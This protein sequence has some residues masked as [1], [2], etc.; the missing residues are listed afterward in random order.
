MSDEAKCISHM[1]INIDQLT[2]LGCVGVANFTMN[3]HIYVV[4][5]RAVQNANF[6]SV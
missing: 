4:N 5:T 2:F 6:T 1:L 3:I